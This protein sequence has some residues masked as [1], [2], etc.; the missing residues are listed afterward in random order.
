MNTR[1]FMAQKLIY[2][3]DIDKTCGS[4]G[5]CPKFVLDEQTR[6]VSLIDKQ[7]NRANMSTEHFNNFVRAVRTGEITMI[8]PLRRK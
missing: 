4:D 8:K 6:V 3:A 2:D 1:D 5:P 7:G